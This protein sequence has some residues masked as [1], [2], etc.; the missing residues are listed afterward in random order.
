MKVTFKKEIRNAIRRS[1][2]YGQQYTDDNCM[3]NIDG[4]YYSE[5]F[6][7]P[8]FKVDE[9]RASSDHYDIIEPENLHRNGFVVLKD[10]VVPYKNF[11]IEIDD[12][13]FNW[14]I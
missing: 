9:N 7:V 5:Y 3:I 2:Y 6:D 14:S 11:E 13:L 8:Y 10:H 12:K 4:I 1:P